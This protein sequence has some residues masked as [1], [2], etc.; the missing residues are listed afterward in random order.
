VKK[1]A[2][3]LTSPAASPS[4]V[5]RRAWEILEA[6]KP[7]DIASRIFDSFIIL[8]IFLNVFAVVVGTV[9][10]VEERFS[11]HLHAFEVFSVAVFTA[12]YLMRLWACAADARYAHPVGGRLRFALT[13]MAL[14]DL[15]ATLPFYLSLAVVDLRVI[16]AF[17]LF[18][19]LR[20][21]K[22]GRYSTTFAL[23]GKVFRTRKE[24]L[25]ITGLLMAFLVVIASSLMYFAE[26]EAQPDKFPD[27]PSTMWWS[28]VTLTTVGYGDVYPVT[29]WGKIFAGTI[30]ILGVGMFAL[31]T[32][33]LGAGFVEEVQ[34]MKDEK[35]CC[36]HCGEPLE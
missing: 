2:S 5:K 36:P 17:R 19:L 12:E 31:P 15:M 35:T 22:L 25:V 6:A 21:A 16:R 26:N 4:S 27:I 13:P 33:I 7:G 11:A 8:L 1:P 14:I 34:K 29:L 24:E 32:G 18:R 10:S 9:Q 23:F 30:A 3:A 28:V 20:I